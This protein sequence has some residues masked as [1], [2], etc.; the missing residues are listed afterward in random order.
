MVDVYDSVC[1]M[2]NN[3]MC[4]GSD[5]LSVHVLTAVL[6]AEEMEGPKHEAGSARTLR[7]GGAWVRPCVAAAG[8]PSPAAARAEAPPAAERRAPCGVPDEPA[9]PVAQ[10]AE[11]T[12]T[13]GTGALWTPPAAP[14]APPA[15]ADPEG[16]ECTVSCPK[17]LA[18]QAVRRSRASGGLFWGCSRWPAC[19][20]TRRYAD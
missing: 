16:R 1:W 15:E 12:G 5:W 7:G 4:C 19:D 2:C 11:A 13:K 14:A 8:G 17:C 10:P 6:R 3:S 9:A 20:G 18:G